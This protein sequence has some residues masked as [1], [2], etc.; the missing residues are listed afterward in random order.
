M[1]GERELIQLYE[2]A[3][4]ELYRE[5]AY[6][7]GVGTT[8]A[9]QRKLLERVR[10]ILKELK[11]K[12][13]S[14]VEAALKPAWAAGV[15]DFVADVKPAGFAL[16]PRINWRQLSILIQNTTDQ[17]TLATNRVGRMWEDTIRRAGIEATRH[18]LATRQ[19][20][21]QM[22]RQLLQELMG[23]AA[24]TPPQE[25]GTNK[26]GQAGIKTRRGVMRLDTYAA[27]VARSTTAEAQHASKLSMAAE[28][29]YD[30]VRFTAHSPKCAR[31]AQFENR[32]YAL[33]REAASGKYKGPNGEP[34]RFPYLYETAFADGYNNIHPNCRH[35]LVIVVASL[36]TPAELAEWS[37]KS[38]RPFV[39]SRSEKD[40]KAY[41]KA[42][43]ENRSRWQDRRQ[44]ERYRAAL[45]D[46]TPMSFGVFRSMKKANA[47]GWRDLQADY[48]MVV[49][50]AKSGI[51]DTGSDAMD[52][53]IEIDRLTPCL[54]DSETGDVVQTSY[55]RA[56]IED[57]KGLKKQGWLFNW[58][59][60][61]LTSDDIFKLTLQ[62]D[63]EIQGLIALRYESRS[64]AVYAH[65][66]ESAPGNRGTDKKYQGVGGHL[67]AIAAKESLE[68][69]FGGFVFLDAKNQDLVKHYEDALGAVLLGMPHPFRMIIDEEAAVKLL[70]KYTL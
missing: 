33:T 39:D 6:R 66:A 53:T 62:G 21:D 48:R 19:T 56:A 17:L 31:C 15:K 26:D 20:V 42:Q 34:L 46:Q 25:M 57:L 18:K 47:Q 9:Y 29:G 23:I 41:A 59:D 43:A 3:V 30:L 2:T 16:E 14:A 22:R 10:A 40:R 49:N 60:D 12:T 58:N 32:M 38:M 27:L 65:I 8:T 55:S 13:P 1:D 11:R 36:M 35:R 45:P 4:K 28:Y 63:D 64:H 54:I 5:I 50:T 70:N 67:F 52:M 44:W 51:M 68:K 24:K 61:A 37:R 7:E 69:G